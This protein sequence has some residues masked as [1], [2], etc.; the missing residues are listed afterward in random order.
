MKETTRKTY[1]TELRE[2]VA[3]R[4][5]STAVGY[6]QLA[7][8]VGASAWTVRDWVRQYRD[9][10]YIGA[11]QMRKAKSI[12]M[13]S[14]QEKLKLVI[15]AKS[16]SEE[17]RGEFLRRSG[18]HDEDLQRWENEALGGLSGAPSSPAQA[19]RIQE[20][21]R[22]AKKQEKRLKEATALLELQKKVQALWGEGDDDTKESSASL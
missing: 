16:I 8:E 22:R 18:V 4:Y 13:R 9:Q 12:D 14:A 2:S 11:T 5:L 21:E 7:V 1:P 3:R 20:L 19:L 15:E 10:G 17:S 6:R